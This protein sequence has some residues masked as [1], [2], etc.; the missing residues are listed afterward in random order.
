MSLAHTFGYFVFKPAATDF[1]KIIFLFKH[2]LIYYINA[3]TWLFYFL[4]IYNHKLKEKIIL[5]ELQRELL[6]IVTQLDIPCWAQD[7]V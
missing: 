2:S 4:K 7:L 6:S 5:K 1:S 3:K